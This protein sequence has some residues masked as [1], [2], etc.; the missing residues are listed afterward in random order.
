MYRNRIKPL[1]ISDLYHPFNDPYDHFDL[2]AIF[3]LSQY[4]IPAIIVDYANNTKI[5]G[6]IPIEQLNDITS[7]LILLVISLIFIIR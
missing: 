2:A 6:K 1:C 5:P 3:A 4:D 7:Q